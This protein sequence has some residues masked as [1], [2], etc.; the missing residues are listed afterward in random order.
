VDE[1]PFKHGLD[2]VRLAQRAFDTRAAAAGE[3]DDEIARTDVTETL[4]VEDERHTRHEV[5]LT[6]DELAAPRNL[7]DDSVCQR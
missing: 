3:S 2:V 4:A 7:D 6:D 1:Q 5:R